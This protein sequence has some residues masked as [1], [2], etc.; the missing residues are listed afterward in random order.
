MPAR[1]RRAAARC[2]RRKFQSPARRA[3]GSARRRSRAARCR[4]PSL[5]RQAQPCATGSG[6]GVVERDIEPARRGEHGDARRLLRP[7]QL[8]AEG[9]AELAGASRSPAPA[10]GTPRRR[11][12]CA[13]AARDSRATR[14]RRR[15]APSTLRG[16][17]S[18]GR[19]RS[20]PTPP[21]SSPCWASAATTK[22]RFSFRVASSGSICSAQP[23]QRPK[24]RQIGATRSG[25]GS[26]ISI[27][28]ARSPLR[29]T[30]TRSPGSVKGT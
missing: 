27:A 2:E 6:S 18:D 14:A 3:T 4:T 20:S 17:G 11:P 8:K 26:S 12:A 22:S 9:C 16:G 5:A 28:R 19:R 10:P 29:S 30:R 21:A 23:P 15:S 1:K 7:Q 25:L 24:C 13:T